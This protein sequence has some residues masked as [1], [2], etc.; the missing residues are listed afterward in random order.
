M[1]T[2]KECLHFEMCNRCDNQIVNHNSWKLAENVELICPH[3]KDKSKF[4]ELPC[5]MGDYIEWRNKLGNIVTL[6]VT[7]FEFDSSG[8]VVNYHTKYSDIQPSI[9]D[10]NLIGVIPKER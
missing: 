1:S 9:N 3:F 2:C 10:E 5:R 4:I 7:G 8:N 6:E